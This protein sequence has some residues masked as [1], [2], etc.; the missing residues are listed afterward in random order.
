MEKCKDDE[1][2]ERIVL[3]E[4]EKLAFDGFDGEDVEFGGLEIAFYRKVR[5]PTTTE[6]IRIKQ[7]HCP[8]SGSER[9]YDDDGDHSYFTDCIN[10]KTL[11]QI[12]TF[13]QKSRVQYEA[14]HTKYLSRNHV[15]FHRIIH[16][17]RFDN[18]WKIKDDSE[19]MQIDFDSFVNSYS[20][21]S[22]GEKAFARFIYSLWDKHHEEIY[23]P[24][25]HLADL[26]EFDEKSRLVFVQWAADPFWA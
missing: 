9:F 25:F 5:Q 10:T 12:V 26:R 19:Y 16:G 21:W 13:W 20:M 7:I 22:E 14:M 3:H 24:Q 2:F 17:T 6:N 18:F 23:L 15:R 8:K 1:V 4:G 11:K